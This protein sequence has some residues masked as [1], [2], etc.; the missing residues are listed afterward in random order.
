MDYACGICQR[1][2]M[3]LKVVSYLRSLAQ[4]SYIGDARSREIIQPHTVNWKG[5]L[6]DTER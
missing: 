3:S 6:E 1:K 4:R 5:R 2:S